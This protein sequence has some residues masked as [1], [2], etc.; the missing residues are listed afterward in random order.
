M[1]IQLLPAVVLLFASVPGFAADT[2]T[3]TPITA[4]PSA[5]PSAT[6][7]DSANGTSAK[8]LAQEIA[9]VKADFETT[10]QCLDEENALKADLAKKKAALNAEY[11][12]KIPV[13]F[14]DLLWQKTLRLNKQHA[15]CFALY[16]A[17]GKRF[18]ALH[19]SFRTIEPKNQNVK[20]QKDEVDAL[21]IRFLQMAPTAKAYNKPAAA[22]KPAA[23]PEA[24]E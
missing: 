7:S 17:L 9:L 8:S 24:A 16:D 2:L 6:S 22:K 11:K 1:R 5:S 15:S 14:N 12:G 13:A 3:P 23:A 18:E 4:S 10:R 20:R 21:K 19:M